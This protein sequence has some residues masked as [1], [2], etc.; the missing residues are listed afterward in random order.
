M[1]TR[2][3]IPSRS[4]RKP[5]WLGRRGAALVELAVCLPVLI[6][7]VFATLETCSAIFLK[8]TL[9]I[10]SYEA[11]RVAVR[12]GATS[13]GAI[14]AATQI[15]DDRQIKGYDIS[16]VP[17]E[18]EQAE[19]GTAVVVRITAPCAANLTAATSFFATSD[20]EGATTMAKE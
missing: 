1:R 12:D 19:E 18:V 13:A 3:P 20:M 17:A 10:A 2:S 6:L 16:I 9:Q 11:V 8:Q 5:V 4:L 15:L 14:S 7:L